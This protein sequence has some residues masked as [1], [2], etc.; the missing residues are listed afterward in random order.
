MIRQTLSRP[1]AGSQQPS[2]A[3]FPQ[4]KP[5]LRRGPYNGSQSS[6]MVPVYPISAKDSFN[7]GYQ[8]NNTGFADTTTP[9]PSL[10]AGVNFLNYFDVVYDPVSGFIGYLPNGSPSGVP[11]NVLLVTPTLA[12]QDNGVR[13]QFTWRF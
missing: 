5:Q 7:Q 8:G 11:A 12:L 13:G 1:A 9:A 4:R 2:D 6:Q 3:E 10:N